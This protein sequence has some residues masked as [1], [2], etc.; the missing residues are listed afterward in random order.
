MK[1]SVPPIRIRR[2]NDRAVHD[3]GDYVLYWMTAFRRVEW[4]FSLQRAVDWSMELNRPLLVLEAL[5]CDYPWAS[6][7]LHQFILDGMAEKARRLKG[8]PVLYYPYVEPGQGAGKGLLETLSERACVVVSDE[9]PAFFLPRALAAAAGRVRTAMEGVD[10]NGI[11]PMRE[12]DRVYP[13]AYAFRRF[14]QKVLPEHLIDA[15]RASPLR[16]IRLPRLA[17]LDQGIEERWTPASPKLLKGGAEV[18]RRLP[19]DHGVAPVDLRGGSGAARR[20]LR[21]FLEDRLQDYAEKR[22]QPQ[23]EATSGLSPYL[24]FGHIS[25]HQVFHELRE[26]EDWFFDRLSEKAA[27]GKAGW[28]GMGAPAEAFLDELITWRELGFNMC[29]Q[30]EDHDRYESLPEW[31]V[32]TLEGHIYDERDYLYNLDE[33]EKGRTH[34]PLWNA[35]QMQ[36]VKEGRIHNYLRMLWGKKILQWSST[37]RKALEVM[38]ELN[39]KY[40]LDGRDPNSFSGIFWILGRY[41]RAWGPERP[42]FGK[43]RYMSCKNTARKVRVKEYIKRYAP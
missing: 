17:S 14:L 30:R 18:M 36:L 37:P 33:F 31:A 22:N 38:I 25:V 26:A 4:N 41:D 11:L 35:A 3:G 29:W 15:P 40:A 34:D 10:S 24:H 6:D 5:R 8:S 39:N 42:I 13:T 2:A 23:V 21:I 19:L 16:G 20:A 32:T 12:A 43:V 1:G 28:W 9:F 7:R 27:G